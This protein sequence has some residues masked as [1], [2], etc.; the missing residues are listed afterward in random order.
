MAGT[1][2]AGLAAPDMT[3]LTRRVAGSINSAVTARVM[4]V[5]RPPGRGVLVRR[6]CVPVVVQ[7]A[8]SDA[9]GL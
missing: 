1:G 9:D 3:G 8:V 2:G 7:V 6:G 5:V 4:A